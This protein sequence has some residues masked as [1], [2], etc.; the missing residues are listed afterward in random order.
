METI[1][2]YGEEHLDESGD[3]DRLRTEHAAYYA[4]FAEEAIAGLAGTDGIEWERRLEAEFDNLRTALTWA[5]DTA[6]VDVALRLFSMFGSPVMWSDVNLYS[7]SA[8][9]GGAHGAS[10]ARSGLRGVR[11]GGPRRR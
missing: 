5:V 2:Q 7:T 3:G 11:A 6:D 10:S 4:A 8:G 1:R 9:R